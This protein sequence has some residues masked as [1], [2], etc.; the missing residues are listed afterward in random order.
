MEIIVIIVR[1]TMPLKVRYIITADKKLVMNLV[2]DFNS[3]KEIG[4]GSDSGVLPSGITPLSDGGFFITWSSNDDKQ[5]GT[6]HD[7]FGQYFNASGVK[8]GPEFQINHISQGQQAQP[9]AV[10]VDGG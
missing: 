5:G 1:E 6:D 10:E 7:L 4:I 3:D 9:E 8:I 2:N